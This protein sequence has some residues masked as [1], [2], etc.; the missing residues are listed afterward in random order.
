MAARGGPPC[1]APEAA[2]GPAQPVLEHG[3]VE[4]VVPHGQQHVVGGE[5]GQ[6]KLGVLLPQVCRALSGCSAHEVPA[7]QHPCAVVADGGGCHVAPVAPGH[8]HC[9]A[10]ELLAVVVDVPEGRQGW[11]GV[12][13]G[14]MR[15]GRGSSQTCA[16]GPFRGHSMPG[17]QRCVVLERFLCLQTPAA[18]HVCALSR[19]LRPTWQTSA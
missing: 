18:V 6:G 11:E 10:V 1:R 4:V 19:C 7:Q 5:L 16:R 12:G 9:D 2:V 8:G 15:V 3:A 14:G 13:G 17:Q